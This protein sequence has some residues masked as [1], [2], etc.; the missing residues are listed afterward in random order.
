MTHT[1]IP[2]MLAVG[3]SLY[4]IGPAVGLSM[5]E[6]AMLMDNP[7]LMLEC[8]RMEVEQRAGYSLPCDD[9]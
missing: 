8:M 2:P 4:A 1:R 5:G 9:A 7:A 3:E 6:V